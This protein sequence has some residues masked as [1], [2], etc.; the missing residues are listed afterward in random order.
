MDLASEFQIA[1]HE[2]QANVIVHADGWVMAD[3]LLLR[4]VLQNLL[5]NSLKYRKDEQNP[6]I[7][8]MTRHLECQETGDTYG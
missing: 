1:I 2:M 3:A 5:D 8:I 7:T 6:Q 4:R